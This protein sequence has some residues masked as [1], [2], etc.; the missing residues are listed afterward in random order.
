MLK[1]NDIRPLDFKD[2]QK[3]NE[4]LDIE[5]LLSRK[6]RFEDV[7]CPTCGTS[8]QKVLF[9]KKEF[10][11]KEC[12]SC[13]MLYLTPRPNVEL[14]GEY[15]SNSHNHK[16][17]NQYIYPSSAEV[18][19]TRIFLPRVESIIKF[20][21]ELNASS[22][23]LLEIG[24]GYGLFLEE[25]VKKNFFKRVCGVEASDTLADSSKE[26]G[27]DIYNGVFELMEIKEKFDVIVSFE[28]IEHIFDPKVLLKKCLTTL[29]DKGLLMMTFP[30]YN[31]F[32]I[33]VLREESDSVCHTH[34]NYFN[35]KSIT[36][37]LEELGYQNIMVT[38]P[39]K[40][41]VDLVRNKIIQGIHTPNSFI[42]N[43]CIEQTEAVRESFQEFLIENKMS[44]NM[45][46]IAQK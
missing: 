15:Y 3:E 31:G 21:K 10:I 45:M 9:T 17:F 14:L 27:F 22:N 16:F 33:G 43:L 44:S 8:T 46:I 12:E 28:V 5:F 30:N 7:S 18:R 26:K 34:L 37:L 35:E 2:K 39:G 1:E 6:N 11:Y 36:M 23:N 4:K 13:T 29:N 32:D 41:D 19:R 20:A 40:L 38:T 24:P 25:M 42:N